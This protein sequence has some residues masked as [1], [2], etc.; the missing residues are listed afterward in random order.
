MTVI[1]ASSR[2]TEEKSRRSPIF[3]SEETNSLGEYQVFA[4]CPPSQE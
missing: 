1:A 4:N 2:C 3:D